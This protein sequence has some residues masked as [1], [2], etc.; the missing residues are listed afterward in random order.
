MMENEYWQKIFSS[1]R[2]G[3]SKRAKPA[4]DSEAGFAR[5]MIEINL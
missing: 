1:A 2:V 5:A 4:S 3:R